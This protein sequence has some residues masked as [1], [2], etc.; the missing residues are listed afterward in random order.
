MLVAS[1]SPTYCLLF[2]MRVGPH[3]D[4]L[5]LGGFAPRS[6]RR[7]FYDPAVSVSFIFSS[8]RVTLPS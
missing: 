2:S 4:A 7:R 5:S 8:C 1:S 6:G 3:P